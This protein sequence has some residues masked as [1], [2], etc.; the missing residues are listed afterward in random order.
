MRGKIVLMKKIYEIYSNL[1][2][3]KDLWVIIDRFGVMR[4][5]VKVPK[6]KIPD[7][8]HRV[9]VIIPETN[10]SDYEF[11]DKPEW[12]TFSNWLHWDLNP[13][14]WTGI[15]PDIDRTYKFDDF[16]T[17]NN[18]FGCSQDGIIKLQG[19]LNLTESVGTDGGF[20]VV[21]G[22][23]KH[24]HEWSEKTKKSP[25]FFEEKTN[26]WLVE[27]PK[28]EWIYTQ[29]VK[30]R[31]RARSI[32]IWRSELPHCNYP[33][34]SNRFRMV[35]YIRYFPAQL[36]GVG[37]DERKKFLQRMIYAVEYRNS[38]RNKLLGIEPY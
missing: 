21:P 4:P 14:K 6:G 5:T 38:F 13:W 10:L 27:L 23:H 30:L 22:F 32:V 15:D 35:Q 34:G 3:R 7:N 2:G 17:E 9:D 8:T 20:Y 36:S 29:G 1:I 31:T 33:N 11:E 24:I 25:Y 18:G 26:H 19:I 28:D 16:P 37:L 12:L